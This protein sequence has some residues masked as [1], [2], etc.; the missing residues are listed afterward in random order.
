MCNVC[1][2]EWVYLFCLKHR[3]KLKPEIN[4]RKNV[5]VW[6]WKFVF[7]LIYFDYWESASERASGREKARCELC[8]NIFCI[9]CTG[10]YYSIGYYH[11]TTPLNAPFSSF[12]SSSQF[13]VSPIALYI[14]NTYP[15]TL[16]IT[17][18]TWCIPFNVWTSE[19]VSECVVCTL[20]VSVCVCVREFWQIIFLWCTFLYIFWDLVKEDWRILG[21]MCR[22]WH[23]LRFTLPK[24]NEK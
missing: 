20:C 10:Y 15:H 2:S 24:K 1:L 18:C 12:S 17:I 8:Y 3:H 23:S 16:Y 14:L 4:E 21:I 6:G 9:W 7:L 22:G 5:I 11:S 19:Q 13:G